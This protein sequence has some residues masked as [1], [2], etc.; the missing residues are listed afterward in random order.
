MLLCCRDDWLVIAEL[1]PCLLEH[2][3]LLLQDLMIV[4]NMEKSDL[5]LTSKAQYLSAGR[6]HLR[7][8]LYHG[9]YDYHIPRCGGQVPSSDISSTKMWQQ[10]LGHMASLGCFVP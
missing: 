1:F 3:E 2:S 4:I 6:H 9:F 5:E 8:V 10:I 7:E